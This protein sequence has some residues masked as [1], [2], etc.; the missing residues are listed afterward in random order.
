MTATFSDNTKSIHNSSEQHQFDPIQLL[1]NPYSNRKPITH[2]R[3][4]KGR[5]M[6]ILRIAERISEPEWQTC[7]ISGEPRIG[8]TSLLHYLAHPDGLEKLDLFRYF[9]NPADYLFVLVEL[10]LLPT[11]DAPGFWRYLFKR[12]DE[13]ATAK[14]KRLGVPKT[15][16]MQSAASAMGPQKAVDAY[17]A[18]QYFETYLLGLQDAVDQRQPE[19]SDTPPQKRV[20][21]LFDDFDILINGF[22]DEDRLPVTEK[23]RALTQTPEF[24]NKL[25]YILMSTDPLLAWDLPT[26][27][28][29]RLPFLG[30][31]Y[32]ESLGLLDL[33]HHE[34]ISEPFEEW[35]Q[36]HRKRKEIPDTLLEHFRFSDTE[37]AFIRRLVGTHPDLLNVACFHLFEAKRAQL[38]KG[39]VSG[40]QEY[41]GHVALHDLEEQVRFAVETDP[42]VRWL[43]NTLWERLQKSEQQTQLPLIDRLLSLAEGKEVIDR[44][45]LRELSKR[46]MVDFTPPRP[47]VF[48]DI[49][50]R[51]LLQ[52]K[53]GLH[54]SALAAGTHLLPPGEEQKASQPLHKRAS[55]APLESRLYRYLADHTGHA[56]SR[57]ELQEAIW[58][59]HLPTSRDAL[60]QLVKRV[61][62]K[63]EPDPERPNH[64]LTIR[65]QGYL[66]KEAI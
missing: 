3:Q 37:I 15:Q 28:T 38:Q 21:L 46:G 18:Q 6:T 58:G 25:N 54:R 60:E 11:R 42:H 33:K 31:L 23:L 47:R 48:G 13:A 41:A 30:D 10:H 51:F 66:L 19:I 36:E 17:M 50:R 16:A 7:A 63:I 8:K 59:E 53:E 62:E 20:V 35:R 56:C 27:K 9:G 45:A 61:R 49:F 44:T 1:T 39:T 22:T 40:E 55:L 64:L 52:Q 32:Y 34:V 2:P 5:Q 43:L 65:G 26:G 57:N 12:L 4:L 14:L 29:K 24:A